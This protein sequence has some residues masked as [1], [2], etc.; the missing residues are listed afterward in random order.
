M[1]SYKVSAD[2]IRD[3]YYSSRERVW[4]VGISRQMTFLLTRDLQRLRMYG[5]RES[6]SDRRIA[7][8]R[9]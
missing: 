7:D 5:I 1:I 8:Q 2:N 9:S 3:H 6:L 4:L